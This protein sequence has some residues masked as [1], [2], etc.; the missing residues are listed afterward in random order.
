MISFQPSPER[1]VITTTA[2]H[3]KLTRNKNI[4]LSQIDIKYV[5]MCGRHVDKITQK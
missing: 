3:I 2:M 1:D 5:R 4:C